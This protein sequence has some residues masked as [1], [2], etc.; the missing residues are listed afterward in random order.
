[1]SLLSLKLFV[2]FNNQIWDPLPIGC[3]LI[4]SSSMWGFLTL[5]DFVTLIPWRV[6]W[7][8][9][10]GFVACFSCQSHLFFSRPIGLTPRT[11]PHSSC[12]VFCT[13]TKISNLSCP[14]YS[15]N[16]LLFCR[17][18]PLKIFKYLTPFYLSGFTGDTSL[19][20]VLIL[21]LIFCPPTSHCLLT[22]HL[23]FIFV[24]KHWD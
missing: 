15:A 13:L 3:S 10:F 8:F 11:T 17:I 16:A 20:R 9:Q 22:L 24:H 5:L 1:M 2:F 18:F 12:T 7:K 23:L 19:W 21:L 4:V 14:W 6:L